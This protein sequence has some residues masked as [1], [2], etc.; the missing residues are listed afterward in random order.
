MWR[1]V[2][3]AFGGR[4]LDALKAG[5]TAAASFLGGRA[6]G[7]GG[8]SGGRLRRLDLVVTSPRVVGEVAAAL[9][10]V[11]PTLTDLRMHF[12]PGAPTALARLFRSACR[13]PALRSL[14]LTAR[15]EEPRGGTLRQNEAAAIADAC[16]GL[17]VLKTN[18]PLGTGF[19][20]PWAVARGALPHLHTLRLM[21]ALD[22]PS[23]LD[24]IDDYA[25]VLS[26]RPMTDVY[27]PRLFGFP[28]AVVTAL[29][30]V[31][32]LPKVLHLGTLL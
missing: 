32:R 25:A 14:H 13:L 7:G 20:P 16:A 5:D 1:T 2:G 28:A 11:S 15:N 19:G 3:A 27:V 30:S 23:T 21:S 8:G 24:L 29:Q 6:T 10:S 17:E 12:L 18:Y 31:D 4:P 9:Q 22:I 26:H